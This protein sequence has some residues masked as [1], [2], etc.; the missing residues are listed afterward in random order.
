MVRT[1]PL[2]LALSV[3]LVVATVGAG[4]VPTGHTAASATGSSTA[5]AGHGGV[6]AAAPSDPVRSDVA[7]MNGSLSEEAIAAS[8]R[9]VYEQPNTTSYLGVP[10][11]QVRQ[12]GHGQ[13]SLDVS[14]A[15]ASDVERLGDSLAERSFEASLA[16]IEDDEKR[17]ARMTEEVERVEERIEA[18]STRQ[19]TAIDEYNSGELTTEQ[20]LHELLVVDAAARQVDSRID[21]LDQAGRQVPGTHPI[22]TQLQVMRASIV[23]LQGTVRNRIQRAVTGDRE[24]LTVYVVTT[25]DGVVLTANDDGFHYREAYLG[26]KRQPNATDQFAQQGGSGVNLADERASELY[27]WTYSL[28][29]PAVAG[30]PDTA[31]YHVSADHPH[32]S[33][34][35]YL[36]GGSQDVY[37]E[38]Q[39]KRL[40]ALPIT[41]VRENATD[42]LRVRVYRTHA[43]GPMRVT[44][45]NPNND[46]PV[47]A[48][49]RVN[50]YEIGSTG[51]D[52]ELWTMTPYDAVRVRAVTPGG[53]TVRV[54]FFAND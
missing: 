9:R 10:D 24:S 19:Q 44:V 42:L 36:D 50:G 31:V 8:I 7:T 12:S 34:D 29:K 49:V 6:V 32:G 17:V 39:T 16:T 27:P 52:G 18:L 23:P 15:V 22:W 30:F 21:S 14:S 25:T 45:S 26:N 47:D 2:L 33:L 5:V 1:R 51:A 20:F 38:L 43:T 4:A 48:S 37:R 13:E 54:R 46:E 3:A 11:S 28:A 35:A 41:R 53:T 40:D